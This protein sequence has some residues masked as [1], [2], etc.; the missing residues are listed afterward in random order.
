MKF[1]LDRIQLTSCAHCQV[2]PQLSRGGR[3]GE[4]SRAKGD[5]AAGCSRSLGSVALP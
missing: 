4:S 3:A 1:S 2:L 5:R